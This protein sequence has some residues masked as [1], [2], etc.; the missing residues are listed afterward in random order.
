[1]ELHG[2]PMGFG[3]VPC[4]LIGGVALHNGAVYLFY[5]G[6]PKIRTDKVLVAHL[7]RMNLNSHLAGQLYAQGAIELENR[8]GGNGTGEKH[9]CLFHFFTTSQFFGRWLCG[10]AIIILKVEFKSREKMRENRVFRK[11]RGG[12]WQKDAWLLPQL[13]NFSL[14][15][16][17]NMP[18]RLFAALQPVH[19]AIVR[20]KHH[21]RGYPGYRVI[22]GHHLHGRVQ[23]DRGQYP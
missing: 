7:A 4:A 20:C 1:M 12:V 22:H 16:G 5:H 11:R 14:G 19:T 13:S 8:F 9:F 15:T 18:C 23:G 17:L 21:C 3:G 6:F 2:F 10:T